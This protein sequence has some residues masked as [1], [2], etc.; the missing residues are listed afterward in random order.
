MIEYKDTSMKVDPIKAI[1]AIIGQNTAIKAEI[2]D[3]KIAY[4][5]IDDSKLSATTKTNLDLAVNAINA[6]LTKQ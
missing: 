1:Q 2:I 6:A 3:G 5:K 4:L